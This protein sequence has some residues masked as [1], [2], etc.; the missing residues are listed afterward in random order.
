MSETSTNE[1]A[2]LALDPFAFHGGTAS[3]ISG[4]G[5]HEPNPDPTYA[6]H[7]PYVPVA[8]GHAHFS[9]RFNR[10]RARFGT[11]WLRVH[12]LPSG[13]QAAA[14]MVT[15][16]R[17]QLNRLVHHGGEAHIRFEAFRGATYAL[18]GLISDRTDAAADGLD[19]RLD[20]PFDEAEA[21]DGIGVDEAAET[22]FGTR[23][24]KAAGQLVSLMPP[25]FE[26]P[27]SQSFTKAQVK[28]RAFRRW[29]KLEDRDDAQTVWQN[30]FILQTLE[31]Y[32]LMQ[33]G[34]RGLIFGGVASVVHKVLTEKSVQYQQISGL[35][36]HAGIEIDI[37]HQ[38]Q[39][40]TEN[41]P[42]NFVANDFLC[43][44]L[45]A[46]EFDDERGAVRFIER[47]MLCLRPSGLAVHIISVRGRSEKIQDNGDILTFDRNALERLALS[48]LS[49]GH[50]VA[51]LKPPSVG[52]ALQSS[53]AVSFGLIVR[54]AGTI[55]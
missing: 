48:L 50:S 47:S 3:C 34:A 37:Q 9:V 25:T 44:T 1:S 28:E 16:E 2:G 38:I 31:R 30:A 39:L 45:A 29:V 52:R 8:R 54:R 32:G 51:R 36:Q 41:L 23:A 10:L 13:P 27:V 22:S 42:G 15:S 5:G 46:N 55:L 6:F 19:I 43:S 33:P 40:N 4:L 35:A 17:L 26:S 20:R 21:D 11:L 53:D 14:R 24:I 7:T 12:M 49:R 18:M